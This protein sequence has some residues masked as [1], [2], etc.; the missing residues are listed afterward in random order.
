M[1][2]MI[3]IVCMSLYVSELLL[4][5]RLFILGLELIQHGGGGGAVIDTAATSVV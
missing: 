2:M 5:E 4:G 3:I 1:M